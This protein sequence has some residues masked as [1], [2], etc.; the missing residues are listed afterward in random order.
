M[1]NAGLIPS[2]KQ[3][4]RCGKQLWRVLV[5]PATNKSERTTL[6]KKD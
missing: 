4:E 3:G 2:I 5:G 1:R 6:L